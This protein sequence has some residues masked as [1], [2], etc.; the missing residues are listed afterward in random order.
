MTENIRIFFLQTF[1]LKI[2]TDSSDFP[3]LNLITEKTL[4]CSGAFPLNPHPDEKD[5]FNDPRLHQAELPAVGGITNARV[6]ARIYARLL[7]DIKDNDGKTT[8]F[9]SKKTLQLATENVTPIGEPDLT[10]FGLPTRYSRG[11][12]QIHGDFFP[13]LN[14]DGFGHRGEHLKTV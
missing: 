7:S 8:C 14:E 5:I 10:V 3:L 9:L 6:V 12:F 13:V 4:T 11:G 1:P 2:N